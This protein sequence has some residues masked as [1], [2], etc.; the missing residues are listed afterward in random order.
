[1][2][3]IPETSGSGRARRG[4]KSVS[5]KDSFMVVRRDVKTNY[6]RE[7]PVV[8]ETIL[9]AKQFGLPD[10]KIDQVATKPYSEFAVSLRRRRKVHT[11]MEGLAPLAS[12]SKG[13]D[14]S[15]LKTRAQLKKDLE[16]LARLDCASKIDTSAAKEATEGE[17]TKSTDGEKPSMEVDKDESPAKEEAPVA[18]RMEGGSKDDEKKADKLSDTANAEKKDGAEEDHTKEEGT[19]ERKDAAAAAAAAAAATDSGKESAKDDPAAAA[20]AAAAAASVPESAPVSKV[21]SSTKIDTPLPVGTPAPVSVGTPAGTGMNPMTPGGIIAGTPAGTTPGVV[22]TEGGSGDLLLAA[23]HKEEQDRQDGTIVTPW[24]RKNVWSKDSKE[25]EVYCWM[26]SDNFS[27]PLDSSTVAFRTMSDSNGTHTLAFS[28]AEWN[29]F[30]EPIAQKDR[31]GWTRATTEY[32]FELVREQNHRWPL[33]EDQFRQVMEEKYL[34]DQKEEEE[35]QRK[36]EEERKQREAEEAANAAKEAE[37]KAAAGTG[38]DSASNAD[39]MAGEK[40][41]GAAD[42]GE[43][44]STPV[45]AEVMDVDSE[46]KADDEKK[47]DATKTSANGDA[48]DTAGAAADAATTDET[49]AK[50]DG[51]TTGSAVGGGA[52]DAS[53][54]AVV[55]NGSDGEKT[56]ADAEAAAAAAA[57]ATG[58]GKDDD[59]TAVQKGAPESGEDDVPKDTVMLDGVPVKLNL[60]IPGVSALVPQ[61]QPRRKKRRKPKVDEKALEE[62]KR[63]EE[64]EAAAK[65]AD[66][67]EE[68]KKAEEEQRQR[69]EEERL[70]LEEEA[71]KAAEPGQM[72]LSG[73]VLPLKVLNKLDELRFPHVE[74]NIE[75]L[76]SWYYKVCAV[77]LEK[78]SM[79]GMSL[80]RDDTEALGY[81]QAFDSRQEKARV[82]QLKRLNAIGESTASVAMQTLYLSLEAAAVEHRRVERWAELE[83]GNSV[84]KLLRN[85]RPPTAF[86]LKRNLTPMIRMQINALTGRTMAAERKRHHHRHH[87]HHQHHG[88]QRQERDEDQQ[89]HGGE[90]GDH[91]PALVHP[92]HYS[93]LQGTVGYLGNLPAQL[94]MQM[95]LQYETL[96]GIRPRIHPNASV[97]G[98]D[99]KKT[100]SSVGLGGAKKEGSLRNTGKAATKSKKG[101]S[102]ASA[103]GPSGAHGDVDG[104]TDGQSLPIAR[105]GAG[106]A[107]GL[108]EPLL[109]TAQS[110]EWTKVMEAEARAKNSTSTA[111]GNAYDPLSGAGGALGDPLGLMSDTPPPGIPGH[112]MAP[113]ETDSSSKDD[114][115]ASAAVIRKRAVIPHTRSDDMAIASSNVDGHAHDKSYWTKLD[116]RVELFTSV[117]LSTA[118]FE[119]RD[120]EKSHHHGH[121]HHHH[122][123][124]HGKHH[125]HH[126]GRKRTHRGSATTTT[127]DGMTLGVGGGVFG[128]GDH[129][130]R[131]SAVGIDAATSAAAA[132]GAAASLSRE[133]RIGHLPSTM[134]WNIVSALRNGGSGA[135]G[136]PGAT[137]VVDSSGAAADAAKAAAAGGLAAAA[138]AGGTSLAANITAG[139][140]VMPSPIAVDVITGPHLRSQLMKAHDPIS[141]TSPTG[142][143]TESCADLLSSLGMDERAIDALLPSQAVGHALMALKDKLALIAQ[144]VC[145]L[146]NLA[147]EEAMLAQCKNLILRSMKAAGFPNHQIAEV[148]IGDY[149]S[150]LRVPGPPTILRGYPGEADAGGTGADDSGAPEA[151]KPDGPAAASGTAA[152]STSGA[153]V[154][155]EQDI[156]TAAVADNDRGETE[157]KDETTAGE[158]QEATDDGVEKTA[159]E[160]N[161][162]LAAA[163]E[164]KNKV[165]DKADK[166]DAEGDDAMAVDETVTAAKKDGNSD[167]DAATKDSG[168]QPP[169]E[170]KMDLDK[171]AA[172]AAHDAAAAAATASAADAEA[173]ENGPEIEE[174]VSVEPLKA[175]P[176]EWEIAT[177]LHSYSRGRSAALL[178][179]EAMR[180]LLEQRHRQQE[181]K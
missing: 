56:A 105:P 126:S 169:E 99:G 160:T 166:D 36:E 63:R 158:A 11:D 9:A 157:D 8:V 22:A 41:D 113:T 13:L 40:A 151:D 103:A 19:E 115:S 97:L 53:P 129:N 32:L 92:E 130:T 177:I 35:K 132:A 51:T 135:S 16:E 39:A 122:H 74:C 7:L 147:H 82:R 55:P 141:A 146:E 42:T 140:E 17:A 76:K 128:G 112:I 15:T 170:E 156:D 67:T 94:Q 174:T 27:R 155:E 165:D 66:K 102:L 150:F 173:A 91:K 71:R 59:A 131:G 161:G 89:H 75:E 121:H 25:H 58:A 93:D 50:E 78:R 179:A 163:Q 152:D 79:L 134:L 171:D 88:H 148:E 137:G 123:G 83:E 85:D 73:S 26:R 144:V 34:R 57:A 149:E 70:R 172:A 23:M 18:A 47:D 62:Q 81:Y 142:R 176:S 153:V 101:A 24:V 120:T 38:G 49:T 124:G 117:P 90:D 133:S 86:M 2:V 111:S 96:F 110:Y 159:P 31:L 168:D 4:I 180:Q 3:N 14:R 127:D 77:V 52:K 28:E 60:V 100:G 80:H 21:P 154:K 109:L 118:P 178:Q 20:A 44:C 139:V 167:G 95:L 12:S 138:S 136:A 61:V 10:D 114:T 69:E 145:Q 119:A 108:V 29:E 87:H 116:G 107:E 98:K 64:A 84:L 37:T 164:N 162:G 65:E 175:I 143:E 181:Q 5:G 54:V 45:S 68:E 46:K 48:C 43:K 125:G 72:S 30:L 106:L 33:I 104:K 1:M 6:K